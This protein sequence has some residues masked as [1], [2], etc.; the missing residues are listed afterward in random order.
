LTHAEDYITFPARTYLSVLMTL[1][2]LNI[3]YHLTDDE[4]TG[5]YQFKGSVVWDCARRFEPNM[6]RNGQVQC[7]SFG[8]TKPLELGRGGCILTDNRELYDAA[9]RMRTDGRDVFKH[10]PWIK[11][12]TFEIG[13]H[14]Y[15]K[16]E[17]CVA[18]LN[19]LRNKQ[20][21]EQL[22]EFY[23]YPDCRELT[24]VPYRKINIG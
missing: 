8:R 11:Q 20:F 15:M 4:W 6:Y 24:I 13:Y 23:N 18:G 21:T 1:Q 10:R 3:P 12:G 16:P 9:S 5:E 19:L 22:P 14:Y 7:I 17:D 2:K